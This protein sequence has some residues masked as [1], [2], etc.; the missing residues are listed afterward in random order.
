MRTAMTLLFFASLCRAQQASGVV[1][2]ETELEKALAAGNGL[3]RLVAFGAYQ[4]REIAVNAIYQATIQART[5]AVVQT[6][7]L[8]P[9]L[10]GFVYSP[11]PQDRLVV[12]LPTGTHEFRFS[13]IQGNAQA[14]NPQAWLG[15][16][17]ELAYTHK[18][19]DHGEAT[20]IVKYVNGRFDNTMK[21]WFRHAGVQYAYDLRAVGTY[22][23]NQDMSGNQ[24][25]SD[26]AL[27]GTMKADKFDL[28]VDERHKFV[29]V[30]A[31]GGRGLKTAT[32]THSVDTCR[33]TLKRGDTTYTWVD[34]TTVKAFFDGKPG[35]PLT[36]WKASGQLRKNGKPYG[37]FE[38]VCK[39]TAPVWK[40][41]KK[42]YHGRLL[43]VLTAP[44]QVVVLEQYRAPGGLFR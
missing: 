19:G 29:L 31:S 13:K 2:G 11:Q 12:K 1:E 28:K 35:R 36:D 30:S 39:I 6:G 24:S 20:L 44:D 3:P 26:Y 17:H 32:A 7:T 41:I 23:F 40:R 25:T 15:A 4:S 38:Y 21:G 5:G 34:A 27:T 33:N 16:N 42:R 43:I 14:P 18:N 37:T 8:T 10:G 22:G 9:R